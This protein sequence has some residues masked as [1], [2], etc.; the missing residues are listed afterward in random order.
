MLARAIT[1][2]SSLL[3]QNGR[4]AALKKMGGACSSAGAAD[5]ET[6]LYRVHGDSFMDST[7]CEKQGT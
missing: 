4:K 6:A 2:S 7:Q 1:S 5:Y 3:M